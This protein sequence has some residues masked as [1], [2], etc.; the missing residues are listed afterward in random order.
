L[1]I[2]ALSVH[3]RAGVYYFFLDAHSLPYTSPQRII[4]GST[5]MAGDRSME[6][7]FCKVFPCAS[8]E[9][10]Y[11]KLLPGH[12]RLGLMDIP[13]GLELPFESCIIFQQSLPMWKFVIPTWELSS[14]RKRIAELARVHEVHGEVHREMIGD[15]T[16]LRL[17]CYARQPDHLEQ[18]C[19][20]LRE[21]GA[22]LAGEECG[23][24]WV[25]FPDTVF[26]VHLAGPRRTDDVDSVDSASELSFVVARTPGDA[27]A[28]AL[29]GLR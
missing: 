3:T 14:C 8:Y 27:A 21:L 19:T 29:Q 22:Q 10:V 9:N 2:C 6:H 18:F 17:E 4:M 11:P 12:V 20:A 15:S 23:V 26:T 24:V 28:M 16:Q 13:A 25:H 5:V 7:A 1:H